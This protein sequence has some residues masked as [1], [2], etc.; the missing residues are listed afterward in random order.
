MGNSAYFQSGDRLQLERM[1][2]D[3]DPIPENTCGT[4]ITSEMLLSTEHVCVDWDVARSLSLVMP[5][6]RARKIA[7]VG[8][9]KYTQRLGG[10][11]VWP[12]VR[13]YAFSSPLGMLILGAW[14]PDDVDWM[15][16]TSAKLM[17]PVEFEHAID[18]AN[19]LAA[20]Q[21]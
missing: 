20:G 3:P 10:E 15:L 21:W 1:V 5:P 14:S 7:T 8:A 9:Y 4:V 6:D 19:W 18:A 2:N 16:R 12:W 11:H 13:F 17:R